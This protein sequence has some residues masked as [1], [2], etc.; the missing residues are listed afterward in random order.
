METWVR[1]YKR[2]G[3]LDVKKKGKPKQDENI[4]Y[5]EKYEILKKY[6]AFLEEVDQEKK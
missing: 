1:I 3:S 6:L 2:D 4:D 5:K